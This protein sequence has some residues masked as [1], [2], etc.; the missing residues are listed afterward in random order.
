MCFIESSKV[1]IHTLSKLQGRS[2]RQEG[3]ILS[4]YWSAEPYR[5]SHPPT[6]LEEIVGGEQ[7]KGLGDKAFQIDRIVSWASDTEKNPA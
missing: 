2:W 5:M 4:F 7:S 6:S 1:W 3:R